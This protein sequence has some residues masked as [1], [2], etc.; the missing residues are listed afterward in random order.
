MMICDIYLKWIE[1]LKRR[2]ENEN[3]E[4]IE[5]SLMVLGLIFIL[6][7]GLGTAV[8]I[9]TYSDF[10]YSDLMENQQL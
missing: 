9:D 6:M 8:S 4:K 2:I 1:T 7:L 5:I 10:E 3:L